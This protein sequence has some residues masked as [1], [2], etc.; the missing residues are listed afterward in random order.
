MQW[1][2]LSLSTVSA[3][4][5]RT[6]CWGNWTKLGQCKPAELLRELSRVSNHLWHKGGPPK[7]CYSG[8]NS[9]QPRA[10]AFHCDSILG[11][12]DY[13]VGETLHI[14]PF[15]GCG[16]TQHPSECVLSRRLCSMPVLCVVH[17]SLLPV[18]SGRWFLTL[19]FLPRLE[20]DCQ[21][22]ILS[23]SLWLLPLMPSGHML[24]PSYPL[25]WMMH[26]TA[27]PCAMCPSMPITVLIT[28]S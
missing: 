5:V 8:F 4:S 16:I 6:G 11:V 24:I 20:A 9:D 18:L 25:S 19:W 27:S 15:P 13:W 2:L 17:S 10:Y 7:P 28:L 12:P 22:I 14:L 21:S 1:Q 23:C 26:K 3:I